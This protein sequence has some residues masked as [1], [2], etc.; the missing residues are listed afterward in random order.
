MS[1]DLNQ[2]ASHESLRKQIYVDYITVSKR[3]ALSTLALLLFYFFA[4]SLLIDVELSATRIAL[5]SLVFLTVGMRF[6]GADFCL[7]RARAMAG[8]PSGLERIDMALLASGIAWG[9][10]LGWDHISFSETIVPWGTFMM[11]GVLTSASVGLSLRFHIIRYFL[12][13]TVSVFLL[14]EF[15]RVYGNPEALREFLIL[16][17]ILLFYAYYLSKRGEEYFKNLWNLYSL[18]AESIEKKED[19][20]ALMD[21]IPGYVSVFSPQKNYLFVNQMLDSRVGSLSDYKLGDMDP[22]SDFVRHVRSFIDGSA[23]SMTTEMDLGIE[24]PSSEG[25]P[26]R[27]LVSMNRSATGQVTVVSI[28]IDE[29]YKNRTELEKSKS[30]VESL[31]SLSTLAQISSGIAHE[32]NNPMSAIL[33]YPELIERQ[34]LKIED[35]QVQEKILKYCGQIQIA[36]D[37]VSGI[38]RNMKTMAS[39]NNIGSI[40]KVDLFEMLNDLYLMVEVKLGDDSVDLIRAE[41]EAETLVW[42]EG[43]KIL[44][45]LL[46]LV[47]N[48]RDAYGVKKQDSDKNRVIR[49]EVIQESGDWVEVAVSDNAGGI[50]EEHRSSIFDH[51]FT[52]KEYGLGVG[53]AVSKNFAESMGGELFVKSYGSPTTFVLKL[54]KVLS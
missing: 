28:D 48:A 19:F 33:G 16:A 31:S 50:S 34:A 8:C 40:S 2:L 39:R 47:W 37:R 38:V 4:T 26:K 51:E 18:R 25:D 3:S 45:I 46:N 35:K 14:T 21:S 13:L 53:L 52:T 32:I 12:F 6:V 9:V 27:F 29:L 10:L 24:C 42:G 5:A 54:R 43:T 11:V 15:A 17:A 7:R 41:T 49:V 36:A 30:I 22:E 20:T 23:Q 1:L 44:Q